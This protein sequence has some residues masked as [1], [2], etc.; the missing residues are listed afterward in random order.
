MV[1]GV[2]PGRERT[3]GQM[4]KPKKHGGFWELQIV[5]HGRGKK[6]LRMQQKAKLGKV[7]GSQIM[8][9]QLSVEE[10]LKLYPKE[11]VSSRWGESNWLC[12]EWIGEIRNQRSESI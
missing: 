11:G 3:C 9:D 1:L 12:L 10:E 7:H 5:W 4:W 2:F 6:P 8:E